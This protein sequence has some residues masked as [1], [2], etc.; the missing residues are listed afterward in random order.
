M[1]NIFNYALFV[2]LGLASA[3]VFGGELSLDPTPASVDSITAREIGG[4]LRFLASDLMRGRDTSS[5]EIRLA[6]EYLAAHLYA[7]GRSR[8][9]TRVPRAAPISSGSRSK[10]SRRSPRAP[11]WS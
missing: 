4:H 11:V 8:W 2:A 10:W 9:A 3:Q 1:R 5:P 7:A 6:A